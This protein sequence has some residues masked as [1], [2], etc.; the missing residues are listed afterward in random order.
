[1]TTAERFTSF[2][3]AING[4]ARPY[5]WQRD[6]VGSIAGTGRWPDIAAPT[7]SGKSSVIDAH[8]FLVAEHAAGRLSARP[9]RRLVLVAPRRVLVDDQFDHATRVAALLDQAA[10]RDDGSPLADAALVL[11]GLCAGASFAG[12]A[13]SLGVWRL[14]GGILLDNGW[15]LEPAACQIICATPQM[16]GSRLLLRGYGGS[17][18]S[19]NLETGLLGHDAV[20][21]VDEAHLHERLVDTA[22]NVAARSP[23]PTAL[24]VVAMS[25]TRSPAPGQAGLTQADLADAELARRVHAHKGIE[26]IASGSGPRDLERAVLD[27]A[28]RA[29]G[30]GTVGVFVNDVPT[31]LR[32]AAALSDDSA[33]VELVCGRLRP[34]D[35]TRLRARRPA[36]LTAAGDPAVDFLVSTQS[37]EVGVD[38]DLPAM[39]TMIA[40]AAALAQRAGRLNRSGRRP[41]SQFTVV[42]PEGLH[43]VQ[44]QVRHAGSGPYEVEELLA[45]A[46]WLDRLGGSISPA[47]IAGSSLPL[48]PRPVL[49]ALRAVDLETLAMTTDAQAADPDPT[50]FL[51]EPQATVAEAGLIARRYLDLDPEVVRQ[52]LVA[53]PPRPHEVATLRLGTA[54]NRIVDKVREGAW[55]VRVENGEIAAVP[56]RESEALRAGDTLV[57]ADG[58]EI[59]TAGVVGLPEGKG[60]TTSFDDVLLEAPAGAATDSV[61]PLAIA[62]VA[63]V[64]AEDRVLASRAGRNALADVVDAVGEPQLADRLRRH[65]RLSELELSWC[66]GAGDATTG[67]LVVRDMRARAEQAPLA[68]AEQPVTLEEHQTAVECR[69]DALIAALGLE[70]LDGDAERLLMAA[71]MHDEGKRHPRFQRRMGSAG[72]PL[73]K[74]LPGHVPDRGDGWRH[75]QL[76]AAYAAR[77]SGGDALLVALVAGHHGHGRPLFDRE[78]GDLLDGWSEC[79]PDVQDWVIRLFG[80]SGRYEILRADAQRRLGVHTLAWLEALLRCADMQVSREGG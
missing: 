19:R 12:H 45:A 34:A 3:A 49:P 41:A 1:M 11:R 5:P 78:A 43:D 58:A 16:W 64:V 40:S 51:E 55:V 75:E 6:L 77:A 7:G 79:P 47:A 71:R 22:R 62:D 32:M 52:A 25:A 13:R 65:R 80:P 31:A 26:L 29:A 76:S 59:C 9:P 37:L 4:G 67:L 36:L 33:T 54:L 60:P 63:P 50:L 17:R 23:G 21:I 30:L 2:F 74:P 10:E 39:V 8:V 73:A 46:D 20:A 48:P 68:A 61:T 56:L 35:V 15:R 14:R 42:V 44:G 18:A 66:D 38:L 53:C 28:I 24:Q 70:T 69:L 72:V 27:G 57:V